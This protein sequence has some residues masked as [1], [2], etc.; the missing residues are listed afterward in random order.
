M[1]AQE[2]ERLHTMGKNYLI[3]G[4]YS[5][6]ET[7]LT[8]AY[9]LDSNNLSITKD[10]ALCF[11]FE[12]EFKRGLDIIKKVIDNGDADE[13]SFQIAG[14]IYKSL[15]QIGECESLYRNALSKFPDNGAINNELGEI[16]FLQNKND[17]IDFWEKGIQKD[18][19][20][21]KNYYNACK[22]YNVQNENV[23]TILYGEIYAN[24]DPFG[25]KTAEIKDIILNAYKKYYNTVINEGALKDKNKFIQKVSTNIN[26]Q[27]YIVADEIS[28][29]RLT[30]VRARF[31]L[32]WYYDKTDK[33][34][35][36]LFELHQQLL[37]EGLFD[38]YNQ[39]LFGSTENLSYFQNWT[40]L[41]N[42]EYATFI[43]YLKSN[44]FKM[45]QDQY[46]H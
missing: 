16:L 2:A 12:K 29:S 5:N 18:P 43:K 7:A 34:P 46:Y 24:M 3:D 40:Q 1:K 11:Y 44:P 21:P 22:F 25:T 36:K 8:N 14:N 28:V 27:A 42:V 9:N 30:M 13:Q 45:P 39:W 37:R 17:C 33:F 31:I 41:H 15:N 32:D 10:L 6:A 4:D 26:K 23:W 38:A 20:Y 19:S 35:F